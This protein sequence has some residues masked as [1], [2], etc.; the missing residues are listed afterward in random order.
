MSQDADRRAHVHDRLHPR[1]L[2]RAS[3]SAARA[4]AS[5]TPSRPRRVRGGADRQRHHRRD[6]RIERVNQAVCRMTGHTARELIGTQLS[7]LAHPED[8]HTSA[9]ALAA[10]VGGA[11]GTRRFEGRYLRR[12]DRLIE[13][14]VAVSRSATTRSEVVQLFTQIEDVTDGAP[15]HAR[16]RAGAVRDARPPRRRRRAARRRHRPAHAPGRRPVGHDRRAPRAA[17]A[18]ARAA[19]LAAA[20]HDVGK[21]AIPDAVLAKRG[22]LTHDEFEHMK[23]HTTVG[24]QMLS[25]SAFEL[26]GWRSRSRSPTTRSGT[27]AATR[28]AWPG[29]PSRSPGGSSRSPT[30]STRSRTSGPTSRRGASPTRSTSSAPVGTPL[31]PAGPGGLPRRARHNGRW[32]PTPSTTRAVA[33]ARQLIDARQYVLDSDWG[34]VQPRPPTRTRSWSRTRGTSTPTWH[35]GLTEGANDETKARYAFVYGDLRRLH[36]MGLIACMYRAA[37]WRHKEIEL[38]AHDLLQHLDATSS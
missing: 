13:A 9:A 15:H 5:A 26:V 25:G 31:R 4:G 22:K 21:I 30:S 33:R 6:G 1:H 38:A 11:S 18:R 20:L 19:R 12:G 36:R 17:R 24:A 35:L 37:E 7:E 34:D 8:R 32:P 10:L 29:T 3:A 2:G 27:A 28:P 16:A 23:T 14:S